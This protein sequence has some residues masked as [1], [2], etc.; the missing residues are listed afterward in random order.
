MFLSH[1]KMFFELLLSKF[2]S[3]QE[4][5]EEEGGNITYLQFP[6]SPLMG[7]QDFIAG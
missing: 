1:S 4:K 7:K 2:V 5:K 3:C 6:D